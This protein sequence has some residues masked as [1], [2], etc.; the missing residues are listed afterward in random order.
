MNQLEAQTRRTATQF[1]LRRGTNAQPVGP[2]SLILK[3]SDL[4]RQRYTV[5]VYISTQC[6]ELKDRAVDEVV[7]FALSHDRTP[8]ELVATKVTRDGIVGYLEI[9]TNK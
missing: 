6:I 1:E 3:D 9:P 4:K 2:V 8:L 5:C 7:V